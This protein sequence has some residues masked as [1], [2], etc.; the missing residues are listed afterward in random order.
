M[1]WS[2]GVAL[3][4]ALGRDELLD[5]LIGFLVAVLLLRRSILF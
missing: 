3:V 1:T 4:I 5:G 2:M